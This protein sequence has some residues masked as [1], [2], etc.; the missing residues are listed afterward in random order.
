MANNEKINIIDFSPEMAAYLEE[1]NQVADVLKTLGMVEQFL[2]Q[3]LLLA[4]DSGWGEDEFVDAIRDTL[5]PYFGVSEAVIETRLIN[6]PKEKTSSYWEGQLEQAKHMLKFASDNKA[7]PI[8]VCDFKN[9]I[10]K[11]NSTAFMDYL[12][13]YTTELKGALL[14]FWIPYESESIRKQVKR[15]LST[16]MPLN[17]IDIP[18]VKRD[19]Q[20]EYISQF[21]NQKGFQLKD[22]C[23]DVLLEWLE[24]KEDAGELKGVQTLENMCETLIYQ[25]ILSNGDVNG[26]ATSIHVCSEDVEKM[27]EEPNPM[28]DA[29]ELMNE[30]IGLSQLKTKIRELVA[31]VKLQKMLVE[32]GRKI[33]SPALHMAFLGNPG[34]GKTTLACIIGKIFQQEGLLKIGNFYEHSGN[35]FLEGNVSE[36][37]RNMRKAC[38]EAYGSIMF[39]DEAYGMAIGHS[40]GNTG[41]DIVPILVEEMENHRDNLCVIFAGYEDEMEVFLKTNSGLKSRIPHVLHFPN[42]NREELEE[43]FFQMVEGT[44][45]YEQELREMLREYLANISDE[46]FEEKEFSNARFVRNLYERVWGKAAYRI[47]FSEDKEIILKEVDLQAALD[48]DMFADMQ[49]KKEKKRIGF[50]MK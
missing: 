12:V 28:E 37:V 50:E 9:H 10:D 34:T 4:M 11:L 36:T 47:N 13:R 2:E 42:Y 5:A 40:N 49:E 18:P 25:K 33:E 32:Q 1:V 29:Y 21:L 16:I 38:K 44:F 3:P 17:T 30:L 8:I 6:V 48:E 39:I 14:I 45:E 43:I 35:E 7:F 31:Q 15:A 26:E 22:D 23:E 24:Q 19:M 41:D 46:K 20:V 27:I